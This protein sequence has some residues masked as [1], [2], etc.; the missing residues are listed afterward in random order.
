[1]NGR[2]RVPLP[3]CRGIPLLKAIN[4]FEVGRNSQQS[5]R[6]YI[7]FSVEN[8]VHATEEY[9]SPGGSQDVTELVRRLVKGA[10]GQVHHR[11]VN[12]GRGRRSGQMR[13]TS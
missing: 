6:V 10:K 5:A 11:A 9:R 2:N 7:D 8:S 4:P 3:S 13:V 1:M 12:A